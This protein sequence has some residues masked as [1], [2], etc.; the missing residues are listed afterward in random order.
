MLVKVKAKKG[1]FLATGLNDYV[2]PAASVAAVGTALG[3][4]LFPPKANATG[5][6]VTRRDL[7]FCGI[8]EFQNYLSLAKSAKFFG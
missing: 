5:T 1:V 4:V 2:A 7:Y 8:H 3:D 6:A